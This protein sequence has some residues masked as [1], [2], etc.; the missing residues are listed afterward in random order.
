MQLPSKPMP[1]VKAFSTLARADGERL[2]VAEHVGEPE[3]HE[4]HVAALDGLHHEILVGIHLSTLL[5]RRGHGA[6]AAVVNPRSPMQQSLQALGCIIAER[7]TAQ[8]LETR[9]NL[10]E[11]PMTHVL[12]KR[13]AHWPAEDARPR[14]PPLLPNL[15]PHVESL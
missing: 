2:H 12:R 4:V 9:F 6:G 11:T 3:A 8:R 15:A 13:G 5:L 14:R 7:K 1:S 10:G